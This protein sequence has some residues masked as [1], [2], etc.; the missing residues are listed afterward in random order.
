[1]RI[2]LLRKGEEIS[3]EDRRFFLGI[4]RIAA[5][6][7]SSVAM[8]AQQVNHLDTQIAIKNEIIDFKDRML[9]SKE[10]ALT[11]MQ[12]QNLCLRRQLHAEKNK[13]NGVL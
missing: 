8:L 1:M 12:Q 9:E 6:L 3:E 10:R 7:K 11:L 4:L 13:N 5:Q 2:R